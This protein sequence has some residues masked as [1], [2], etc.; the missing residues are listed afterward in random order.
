MDYSTRSLVGYTGAG[1]LAIRTAPTPAPAP[2]VDLVALQAASRVLQ[3][4]HNKDATI[5]PDLGDMLTIRESWCIYRLASQCLNLLLSQLGAP[6]LAAIA[7]FRMITGSH[8]KRNDFLESLRMFS[9]FILV[10]H[11]NIWCCESS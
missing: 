3:E 2:V 1:T 5:I 4:Q 11:C 8:S 7:Y 10:S 6:R 9:S